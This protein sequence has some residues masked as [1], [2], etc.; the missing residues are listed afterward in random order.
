MTGKS[1]AL[2]PILDALEQFL[3]S[4]DTPRWG[5]GR[6]CDPWNPPLANWETKKNTLLIQTTK[7]FCWR[8]FFL[9]H[10][11]KGSDVYWKIYIKKI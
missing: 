11:V 6:S 9:F 10:L 3:V 7:N 8:G 2:E 1:L 5:P 4:G